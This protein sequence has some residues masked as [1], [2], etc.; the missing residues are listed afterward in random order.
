MPYSKRYTW[1][2][3]YKCI[4]SKFPPAKPGALIWEPLKAAKRGRL[5]GP[6]SWSHLSVANQCHR[7]ICSRR[8]SGSTCTLPASWIL[9][10]TSTARTTFFF[11]TSEWISHD[12]CIPICYGLGFRCR[13][14][15]LSFHRLLGVSRFIVSQLDSCK[16]QTSTATPA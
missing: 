1:L 9:H 13:P 7:F 5:R 6:C 11:Y 4:N 2:L 15:R 3:H 8:V 16:C 12:I 10:A 14:S